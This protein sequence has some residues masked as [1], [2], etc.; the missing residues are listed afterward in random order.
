MRSLNGN[1]DQNSLTMGAL[2]YDFKEDST[3]AQN[4]MTMEFL[5][6]YNEI[7]LSG[8]VCRS[9]RRVPTKPNQIVLTGTMSSQ[10]LAN[11]LR[12]PPN[13]RKPSNFNHF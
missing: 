12:Y 5:K 9:G 1:Q 10:N 8:T 7:G 11:F 6:L 3:M 4:G 2:K 13:V